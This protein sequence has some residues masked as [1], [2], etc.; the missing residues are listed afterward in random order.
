MIFTRRPT[1]CSPPWKTS[2]PPFDRRGRCI[3]PSLTKLHEETIRTTLG[4][5]ADHWRDTALRGVRCRW[6]RAARPGRG[7]HDGGGG[8]GAGAG[9]PG[10]RHAS[11][12]DAAREVADATGLSKMSVRRRSGAVKAMSALAGFAAGSAYLYLHG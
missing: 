6:W 12:T 7:R 3:A 9:S 4:Q 2:P 1:S 8:R 5:A 11:P 10:R